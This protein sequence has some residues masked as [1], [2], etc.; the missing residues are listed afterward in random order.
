[1]DESRQSNI[2]INKD[3]NNREQS[4]PSKNQE[5]KKEDNNF[6]LQYSPRTEYSVKLEEEEEMYSELKQNFDPITIKIIKKHFKERLGALKKEE[7]VAILKN[8]L[9]GFLPDHPDREKIM[10]RLLSRLFGDIDL[11]DNGD[12]EWNEFTNY[13]IHLGGSGG[14]SKSNV[15]Y[16]LK[17]YS[18]SEMNILPSDLT[19]QIVYSFYIEKYNALGVVEENKSVIKFFD[20]KTCAKL[21]ISIDLKDIQKSVDL[22]EFNKLKEKAKKIILQEEE[23]KIKQITMNK[24]GFDANT[25]INNLKNNKRKK[26]K[27]IENFEIGNEEEEEKIIY[28]SYKNNKNKKN[29]KSTKKKERP[30]VYRKLSVL[31]SCFIPDYD[32]LMISSTNNTIT[33]WKFTR[34]EI[35]NVNVTSEYRFS[36]DELKIAIFITSSPQTSMVWDS[37]QKCLLTGQSDGKILKWDLTNPNPILEDTLN[38]ATVMEKVSKSHLSKK[39]NQEIMESKRLMQLLREK[40]VRHKDLISSP[41]VFED[42][43]KNMAVSYLLILKKLQLLAASYY[44]GYV[45]LWDTIL[46][47]YRKCYFDQS[48][49]IYSIAYDSIRNLLF[50]SGFLYRWEF[51]I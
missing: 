14:G 47:E 40:S 15:A 23:K 34:N 10:V 16:R 7:M 29:K 51:D 45:I 32:L 18:K 19:E 25:G 8:H 48:T 28:E 41:Y 12:L 24:E 38:I 27:E 31:C 50:A 37:Q 17:F 49:A 44:N 3:R 46:K 4:P 9:L 36:K 20:G 30:I 21:K 39:D 33:A 26:K 35:K 43:S 6:I 2:E 42:K 13:I 5:E 1:M 11:N 22:V